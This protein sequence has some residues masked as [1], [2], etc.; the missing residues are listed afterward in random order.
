MSLGMLPALGGAFANRN[1]RRERDGPGNGRATLEVDS[2]EHRRSSLQ[3]VVSVE[4]DLDAASQF[5]QA[6]AQA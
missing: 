3:H 1:E 6:S 4:A 2:G 5:W